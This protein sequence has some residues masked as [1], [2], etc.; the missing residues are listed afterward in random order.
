MQEFQL[1]C[2]ELGER[3]RNQAYT[4]NVAAGTVETGHQ[5]SCDGIAAYNEDDGDRRRRG[6]RGTRRDGISGRSDYRNLMPYELVRERR[7]SIVSSLRPAVFDNHIPT[8]NAGGFTEA[9]MKRSH[10]VRAFSR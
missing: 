7:E 9:L 5:A 1:L 4:S 10:K 2:H 8:I 6:L 3:G